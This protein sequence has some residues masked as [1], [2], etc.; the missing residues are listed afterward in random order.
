MTR[1]E[2]SNCNEVV[3]VTADILSLPFVCQDCAQEAVFQEAMKPASSQ[4][5]A[6]ESNHDGA[7]VENTT[8]LIA[9]LEE[10]VRQR[11]QKIKELAERVKQSDFYR[12]NL[13]ADRISLAKEIREKSIFY[14][15]K[16]IYWQIK[17]YEARE[18]L[19]SLK[20]RGFWS[21]LFNRV[22]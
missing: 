3:E 7:T 4:T 6:P 17:C 2:C 5:P 18:S 22:A 21:R 16:S 20:S 15:E 19:Y 14:Q 13:S 1:I 9:D 11:D 8:L 10:Q 12:A